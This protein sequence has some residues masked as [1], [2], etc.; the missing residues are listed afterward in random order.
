MTLDEFNKE[1]QAGN[2]Q[3]ETSDEVTSAPTL[4][5]TPIDQ[6]L[7]ILTQLQS[8]QQCLTAA[9]TFIP[10]TF[11]EQLQFVYTGGNY[12]LYLYFKDQWNQFSITG[13]SGVTQL[14]AGT[15]I[16]ISPGGGTGTVTINNT[17][18]LSLTAG[19]GIGISGSTG[20]ITISATSSSSFAVSSG[21]IPDISIGSINMTTTPQ[22]N[23]T[24]VTHGLGTTPK[25]ITITI[26]N[27][28]VPGNSG[29]SQVYD[30]VFMYITFDGSGNAVSGLTNYTVTGSSIPANGGLTTAWTK[31]ASTSSGTMNLSLQS[32]GPTTFTF[33]VTYYCSSGTISVSQQV[34][35]I[36]YMCQ[37]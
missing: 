27:F 17:G 18:V 13:G 26:N 22:N 16:S 31:T 2:V 32:I 35:G 29:G 21:T 23:D 30:F 14:L 8:T 7:P 25:L 9:P 4:P 19:T 15:G 34:T 5:G 12:Y 1:G 10:Q 3:V 33:R 11:Q 37:G 20:N 36:T 24:V 28:Q 6:F